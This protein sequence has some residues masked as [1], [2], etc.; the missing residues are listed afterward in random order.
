[1]AATLAILGCAGSAG[2]GMIYINSGQVQVSSI[3]S[4]VAQAK[5]RLSNTNFDQSLDRGTGTSA[6]NF[7]S[8]GLGNNA[9]LSA[10]TYEFALENR[11]GEGLVFTMTDQTGLSASTLSWGTFS[12]VNAGTSVATING[13][14]APTAFNSLRFEA[15]STR[16]GSSLGFSGMTFT[17]PTLSLADGAFASATI[18]P[19]S[20]GPGE[21]NGFY[22][23][24]LVGDTNL[25]LHAWT[26]RGLVTA[27][28]DSTASGDETVK[29]TVSV[30]DV[31][32]TAVPTA[33]TAGLS[34]VVGLVAMRRPRRN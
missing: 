14:A 27:S 7:I 24:R 22:S 20:G 3:N 12:T 8:A 19:S 6:G 18:S 23:Q 21:A 30:Q 10:R 5:Y 13:V 9:Q 2:A 28:R 17:S 29:F 34:G 32:V 31:T 11:P 33:G 26:F 4:T 16:A 1:L 15:S 25:A